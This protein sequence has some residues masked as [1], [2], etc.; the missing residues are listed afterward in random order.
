MRYAF[1][2][3]LIGLSTQAF[4]CPDELLL[5]R[6]GEKIRGSANLSPI[7]QERAKALAKFFTTPNTQ[8]SQPTF[9]LGVEDR[10]NRPVET[11]LPT[12]KALH[13]I[14]HVGFTLREEANG[15][16]AHHLLSQTGTG[17]VCLEHHRIPALV[18]D[19]TAGKVNLGKWK[20]DVFDRVLV[21][22][23]KNVNGQCQFLSYEDIREDVLPDEDVT[24][25]CCTKG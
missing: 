8:F 4:A 11:C 3:T 18:R 17:L 7:G 1:L 25:K 9:V 12:A 2:A 19:L 24:G 23:F 21:M 10:S 22:H 5:I 13:V 6:H 20:G 15:Q 16:L 14:P